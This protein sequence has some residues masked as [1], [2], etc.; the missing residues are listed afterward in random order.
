MMHA[1]WECKQLLTVWEK[2]FGWILKDHP[3]IS[4]FTDLVALVGEQAKRLEL[5]AMI[6]W[7]IWC[8]GNKVRCNELS[9]PLGKILESAAS[10]LMEFQG[11]IW[12][13]VKASMQQYIK[14]K[15]P[16][17]SVVKTNFDG[18]MF[19]KS[20]QAGIGVVVRIQRGQVM[21][22]LAEKNTQTSIHR[23]TR[24]SGSI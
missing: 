6:A 22:A 13:G 7:F 20:D 3:A 21:A 10:L 1:L 12:S 19:A 4:H 2:V 15:T 18:A 24:G 14:W 8:H 16:E 23:Y 11:H 9:V 5:F 17:G